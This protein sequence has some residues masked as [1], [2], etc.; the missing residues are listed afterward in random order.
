MP[1]A[2]DHG[3]CLAHFSQAVPGNHHPRYGSVKVQ[4]AA[5]LEV[6][7]DDALAVKSQQ[8]W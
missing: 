4:A 7:R 3:P 6:D 1:Q 5:I 2:D 8:R